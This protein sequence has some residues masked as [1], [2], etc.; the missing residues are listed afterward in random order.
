MGYLGAEKDTYTNS[1]DR[2]AV[3]RNSR[4]RVLVA[5]VNLC[6]LVDGRLW[7]HSSWCCPIAIVVCRGLCITECLRPRLDAVGV[8][9]CRHRRGNLI[10][11]GWVYRCHARPVTEVR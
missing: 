6:T 3:A 4:S 9:A 7:E 2:I 8:E 1:K 5:V 10:R 11:A